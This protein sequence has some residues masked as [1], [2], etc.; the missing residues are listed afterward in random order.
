VRQVPFWAFKAMKKVVVG[1]GELPDIL[2]L[3]FIVLFTLKI[4]GIVDWSWW[5][6]FSP[7]IAPMSILLLV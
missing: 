2:T 7:I 4:F 1:S 5:I 3:A 6:I